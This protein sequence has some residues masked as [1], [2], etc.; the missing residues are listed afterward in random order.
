MGVPWTAR[1]S[2]QSILKEINPEYSL[3]GLKQ[4]LQYF[5]QSTPILWPPDAKK[6]LIRKYPMLGK[7]EGKS[8]GDNRGR[9]G[10]M[11]SLTQCTWAWASSGRWW[12]T[13]KHECATVHGVT[14]SRTQL[15]DWT[16]TTKQFLSDT[17]CVRVLVTWVKREGMRF[18]KQKR[19]YYSSLKQLYLIRQ[20]VLGSYL[21]LLL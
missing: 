18:K 8:R 19:R 12:R 20:I 17:V 13:G 10:W 4:K 6:Q 3:E 7:I 15:S 16:T 1:R 2:N 21:S 5:S 11:A 9:D 14:K